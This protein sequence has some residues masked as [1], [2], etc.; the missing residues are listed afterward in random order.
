MQKQRLNNIPVKT[1][2]TIGILA[3]VHSDDIISPYFFLRFLFSPANKEYALSC[4]KVLCSLNVFHFIKPSISSWI[5]NF[6]RVET[7]DLLH[8]YFGLFWF[9]KSTCLL[10]I[11]I[12]YK[13]IQ[14]IT[15]KILA[16]N[17]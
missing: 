2:S 14:K 7:W 12:F 9:M 5:T 8:L 17:N 6:L 10:Y 1:K 4:Q 15:S 16:S 11:F 3:M 13:D